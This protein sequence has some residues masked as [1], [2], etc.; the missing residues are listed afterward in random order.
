[1][2]EGYG[3]YMSEGYGLAG[4]RAELYLGSVLALV[5]F[6]LAGLFE[7]NW[8]DAEVK[9]L[10]LFALMMPLCLALA[11]AGDAGDADDAGEAGDA[12]N[13][14]EKPAAPPPSPGAGAAAAVGD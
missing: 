1:M 11:D 9:R 14:R 12:G 10:A 3:L 13:A 5:A 8:G 6:N 7:N 4:P 2:S